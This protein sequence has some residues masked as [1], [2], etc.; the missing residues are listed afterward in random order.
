[1]AAGETALVVATEA[2]VRAFETA[3]R[4]A[5]ADIAAAQESGT[6]ILL[7][8]AQTLARFMTADGPSAVAFDAVIGDLVRGA[9]NAGQQVRAYGEMVAL[10]WADEQVVA[11]IE[12]ERL[13][14]DLAQEVSF[15]LLCAYP[16]ASVTGTEVADEF[17]HVCGLHS[18]V[19]APGALLSNGPPRVQAVTREF[20]PSVHS[21]RAARL[22]TAETLTGWGHANVVPD[23]AVVV[24]E[25]AT[26]ALLHANSGFAVELSRQG[27]SLRITVRDAAR[28]PPAPRTAAPTAESGRG[29]G[30]VAAIAH[31]WGHQS[32][33]GGKLVW[34]ELTV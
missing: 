29:L 17:A 8:A 5:G 20:A 18:S 1:L 10:L 16:T 6:L 23:A 9:R 34:A 25:L 31:R 14:N 24:T 26:N 7:D 4:G 15:S 21:A 28:P 2:H 30:L 13:W 3:L 12:L 22:F 11:A 19:V 32:L 33:A 27:E